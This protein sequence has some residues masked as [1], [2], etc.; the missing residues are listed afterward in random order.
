MTLKMLDIMGSFNGAADDLGGTSRYI[1]RLYI[2][3]WGFNGA[4]DDLGGTR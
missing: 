3:L 2:E 4:A 1:E